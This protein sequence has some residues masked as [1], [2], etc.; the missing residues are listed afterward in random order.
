MGAVE[1]D[2]WFSKLALRPRA[3]VVA[4]M[5]AAP[6][7]LPV[8]VASFER[9]LS[10]GS[11]TSEDVDDCLVPTFDDF[12]A[13]PHHASDDIKM[14]PVAEDL[15]FESIPED[16]ALSAPLVD[17]GISPVVPTSPIFP[18]PTVSTIVAVAKPAAPSR[19][20]TPKA[21]AAVTTSSARKRTSTAAKAKA[22][23]AAKAPKAAVKK[24]AQRIRKRDGNRRAAKKFREKQKQ[25]ET[26]LLESCARLEASNTAMERELAELA[27]ILAERRR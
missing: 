24:V 3:S 11:F 12:D 1:D 16:V 19:K 23:A 2:L 25:H 9:A 27:L 22:S 8:P 20:R 14:E 6:P 17:A 4:V 13:L 7:T 15:Y 5:L 26:E 21:G 18:E 10:D